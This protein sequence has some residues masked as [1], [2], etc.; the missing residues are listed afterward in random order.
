MKGQIFIITI[1]A[2]KSLSTISFESLR[3]FI[4]NKKILAKTEKK[5]DTI[6]YNKQLNL[7]SPLEQ[8]NF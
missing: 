1:G 2:T 5:T 8:L 4:V 3:K 6:S 7:L